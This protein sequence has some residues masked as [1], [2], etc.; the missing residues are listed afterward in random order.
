MCSWPTTSSNPVGLYF[1]AE[2]TKFSILR[3][4]IKVGS[5]QKTV[6]KKNR[7][8]LKFSPYIKDINY[9]NQELFSH[10]ICLSIAFPILRYRYDRDLRTAYCL[11]SIAYFWTASH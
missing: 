4:D 3:Q 8:N 11:L 6:G 10:Y 7:P 5:R 1:R 2:T 9:L